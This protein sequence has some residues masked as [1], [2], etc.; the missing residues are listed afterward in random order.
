M[1]GAD[2]LALLLNFAATGMMI[3]IIFFVQIVHYPLF[4]RVG[5]EGFAR[6]EA[7]HSRRTTIVVVVPMLVELATGAWLLFRTPAGMPSWVFSVG[8][9]LITVVWLS[10]FLLQVPRH[11]L[12]GRGWNEGA[13]RALVATNWIRTVA[14]AARGSLLLWALGGV[15]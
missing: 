11:T 9:A 10:T 15:L 5:R 1:N 13:H 2:R 6:Y 4:A 12:L 14:W 8:F 7:E 3:G